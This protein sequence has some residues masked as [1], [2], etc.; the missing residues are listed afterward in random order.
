MGA[1][2][3]LGARLGAHS[4][5]RAGARLARPLI[6]IVSCAMALRL[7]SAPGAPL[8]LWFEPFLRGAAG[9]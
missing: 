1:G 5:L 3:L 4:A 2:A 7:A 6:V 8:R 9:G